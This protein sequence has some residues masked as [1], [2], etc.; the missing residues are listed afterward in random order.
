M[1]ITDRLYELLHQEICA[2][3]KAEHKDKDLPLEVMPY[4]L[5][6][7]SVYVTHM[8][9]NEIHLYNALLAADVDGNNGVTITEV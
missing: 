5:F 1:N 4:R 2:Q 7:D 6:L 9:K 8:F 3:V